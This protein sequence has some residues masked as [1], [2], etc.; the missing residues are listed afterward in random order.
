MAMSGYGGGDSQLVNCSSEDGHRHSCQ[1]NGNGGRVSLAKQRSGSPCVEGSTWGY[2]DREI[3]V[4][5]GCRADFTVEARY[6]RGGHGGYGGNGGGD[7]QLVN[8]SS[9]DGHRHACQIDGN[10]GRVS[11]SK[12]R[13]GSPCIEGSTWGY[14]D[15]EI[16]V[17]R[18]CRA[19]FTV[20][21]RYDR[22]GH[23]GSWRQRWR[24]CR[25]VPQ[26]FIRG[27]SSQILPGRH[28]GTGANGKTTQRFGMPPGIQL[29]L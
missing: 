26:L 21:A 24:P 25:P 27:W 22:G 1:I 29:G 15:R 3:W 7:S 28:A 8:C 14:N 16:W 4:D 20:E 18:G 13:S 23:G 11:L 12:Q 2:N 19:D 9:E 6:D 10:G 17:D 5:R